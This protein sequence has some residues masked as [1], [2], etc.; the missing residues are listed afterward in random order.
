MTARII[1]ITPV[2]PVRSLA[3]KITEKGI[4]YDLDS[5]TV[6]VTIDKVGRVE[7]DP[8]TLSILSRI[9]RSEPRSNYPWVYHG[10]QAHF[11]IDTFKETEFLVSF[12]VPSHRN[13]III[14]KNDIE[15][16]LDVIDAAWRKG[17]GIKNRQ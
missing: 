1:D 2:R 4:F 13:R 15:D 10:S 5:G 14:N 7:F 12:K 3:D 17:I 6:M 9:L 8:G 16:F 11:I